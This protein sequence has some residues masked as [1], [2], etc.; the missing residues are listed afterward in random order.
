MGTRFKDV[1]EKFMYPLFVPVDINGGK[2]GNYVSM[3]LYK[4]AKITV[5][6]GACGRTCNMTISRAKTVTGGSAESWENW[7]Y[8]M[9]NA[10]VSAYNAEDASDTTV[11]TKTAVSSYTKATGTTANQKWVIEFDSIDIDP[12]NEGFD[13]F[14][15]IFSNPGGTGDVIGADVEL[16]GARYLDNMPPSA[17]S[18]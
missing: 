13:C 15:V 12:D 10:N 1:Y 8:V 16:S 5:N 18:N 6:I 7:D 4:H 11:F 17:R 14:T 9:V 2:T 3:K